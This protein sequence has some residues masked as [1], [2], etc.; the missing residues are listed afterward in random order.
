MKN[1]YN[2]GGIKV[3]THA[4]AWGAALSLP[5]LLDS[6]HG[7]HHHENDALDKSFFYLNFFTNLLWIGPFYLNAYLL[8]PQL[9]YRRRYMGYGLVL[10]LAFGLVMVSNFLLFRI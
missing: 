5:Y 9:F 6:H 7:M 1:W 8:M 2:R 10:A 3:L 4:A